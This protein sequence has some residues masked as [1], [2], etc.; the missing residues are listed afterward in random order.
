MDFNEVKKL[1]KAEE[2]EKLG[3]LLSA[4]EI[5]ASDY[6]RLLQLTDSE[7][8]L[9][10]VRKR[11]MDAKRSGPGTEGERKENIGGDRS[12]SQSALEGVLTGNAQKDRSIKM[13]FDAFKTNI[14]DCNDASAAQIAR[15]IGLE[16]FG[17]EASEIPRLIRSKCLNLKDRDNPGLCRGVYSG[18]ISPAEYVDMTPE[19]M[20]SE[21]L[22]N[23]ETRMRKDSFY[24]CQIPTQKAET[25]MFKCGKCGQ[26]KCSY[27][28]LQTRSADE[29]MTTFV[30]CECGH[31]W[32]F[33]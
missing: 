28:Q 10:M 25:D 14:P 11:C 32:R 9:R 33:C 29:P 19:E 20:K 21:S 26:R 8:V 31:K 17:R 7:D 13:F 6:K 30:T 3:A 4:A 1:I 18:D 12:D 5:S 23:E 16:I 22:R 2:L 15:K 24:E 27:R